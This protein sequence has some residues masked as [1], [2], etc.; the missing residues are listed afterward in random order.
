MEEKHRGVH[1]IE[2]LAGLFSIYAAKKCLV[3]K[4]V[5]TVLRLLQ[6]APGPTSVLCAS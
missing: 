3:L 1:E 4:T 6:K 2:T 5:F